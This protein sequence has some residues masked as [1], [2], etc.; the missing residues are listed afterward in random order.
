MTRKGFIGNLKDS[1]IILKKNYRLLWIPILAEL[2]F[3]ILFGFFFGPFRNSIGNNLLS[4]GD[5]IVNE[6]SNVGSNIWGSVLKSGYFANIIILSAILA[7]IAYVLYCLFQGFIWR[8]CFNLTSK[9]EKHLPYI[10]KFFMVNLFWYVPFILYVIINFSLTY[11][12]FVGQKFEPSGTFILG[13]L[14]NII[15]IVILYFS[16]ISYALIDKTSVWQ[17]IKK[18]LYLGTRKVAQLYP[19]VIAMILFLVIYMIVG[20]INLI[21]FWLFLVIAIIVIPLTMIWARIFIK[22]SVGNL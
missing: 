22:Q 13:E 1:L 2:L 17:S 10:K 14:S 21:S 8:F 20:L 7:F 16:F 3:L 18:S 4:L 9:R 12:D 15:L 6:S 11:L 5:M 19:L